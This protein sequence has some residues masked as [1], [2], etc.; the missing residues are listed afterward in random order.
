MH[1]IVPFNGKYFVKDSTK[2]CHDKVD[3]QHATFVFSSIH[4]DICRMNFKKVAAEDIAYFASVEGI[5]SILQDEET[6]KYCA[7]DQTEDLCYLPEVVLQPETVEAVS[8]IM[9]YCNLHHIPVTPRGAGTGLSGGALPVNGGVVLDMKRFNKILHVDK[10]NLQV[11][12]EPGVITQILQERVKEH[13]LMYPPDP[14]S[15]GSCFIG[16]NVSENSGGPRAVKYGVVKDYVLNIEMVLPNGEEM[17]T[18]AN[19]LKN[20]TGYNLTQLVVGSEGTLGV[21]TKIVLRLIPAVQHDLLMLVPFRSAFEA[22]EAVN[23]IFLAG[24][25][26]SAL[27]FME[28]D[29]LE[30]SM[31]YVQSAGVSLP[32]DI[33]AHLLIEVDGN[34]PDELYRD[35]EAISEIVQKFDIDEILFADSHEQKQMLW[36]LRRK[37]G[38]A[39]KSNSI[40]KEEDTV[41]PRAELPELLQII[42]RIGN[43]YGFKSVC[44]GHAGDGNLHVNIVKAGMSDEDWEQKL[45]QGIRQLFKEVVRMGGTISGEHGIGLVQKGYM[46]IAFSTVQLGLM[47]QIKNI[48]DP[49]GI[50]NPGKIFAD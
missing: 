38:E 48:F 11:T 2:L 17:W 45:P 39:V 37:V 28:R 50:L 6:L 44:Y 34:H 23:A 12:T 7:S 13:G 46:D 42:K 36:T 24:Y 4:I 26:P 9:R 31:R 5:H 19:V 47:K 41:V 43:E 14:A 35:M 22:C 40:Y 15:K 16:G 8:H 3:N 10:R 32:D 33:Q 18:G 25:T 30:W 20:A 29:A 49:N 27:E 21:I 1:Y